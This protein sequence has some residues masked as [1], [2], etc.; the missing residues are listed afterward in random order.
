MQRQQMKREH[1]IAL[2]Q[3]ADST[4]LLMKHKRQLTTPRSI[5]CKAND[6]TKSERA[7]KKPV[8]AT[9]HRLTTEEWRRQKP[10]LLNGPSLMFIVAT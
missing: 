8:T 4:D 10:E 2:K 3:R 1:F 7:S 5:N 6:G 9:T